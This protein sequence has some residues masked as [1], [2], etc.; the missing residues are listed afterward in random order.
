M[1]RPVSSRADDPRGVRE[2]MTQSR[3]VSHMGTRT[4]LN[5]ASGGSNTMLLELAAQGDQMAW[6]QLVDKY[7]HLVR[8]VA[9]SFRLQ[10]ADVYDAAQTTWLRLVQN[11]HTIRDPVRLAGWL[12]ITATRESWSLLRQ[13]SRHDLGSI[14]ETTPDSDPAVDPEGSVAASDAAQHLWATLEELP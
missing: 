13:A 3:V 7:D 12:S 9:G 10:A 1:T 2:L 5:A 8:S 14:V 4:Y 6:R 11:L